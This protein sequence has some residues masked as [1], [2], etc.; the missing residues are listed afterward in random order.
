MKLVNMET[1]IEEDWE[2]KDVVL[3]EN[4]V[5][6]VI[7]DGVLSIDFSE[8]VYGLIEQSMSKTLVVKLLGRNISYNTLWNKIE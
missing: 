4:D 8:K 1:E 6:K 3:Q 5:S 7:E 2:V